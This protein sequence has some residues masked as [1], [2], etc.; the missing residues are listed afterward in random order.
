MRPS[1]LSQRVRDLRSSEIRDLLRL[2]EAPHVL[3]L[4]GGLPDPAGF[5]TAAL[6]RAAATVAGD[7][8]AL[9]YG[10]T[11]GLGEL[12]EHIAARAGE[13]LGRI[14]PVDE[15]VVTTGSQQ[16]L[17]LVARALCDPGDVVVVEDPGYLG[18]L[19][20]LRAAGVRV[21][22][23]PVDDDGLRVDSLDALLR[24]GLRPRLVYTV[25]TF[26]N[27]TG[28]TL[29]AERRAALAALAD[30]HGVVV[31]EDAPYEDLRFRGAS[32]PPVAAGTDRVVSLGSFSKTIAPGLRVGWARGPVD[33]VRALVTLK[34]ATDL[35]TS[36]LAQHLVLAL[37]RR[38]GWLDAHIA[39]SAAS[40]ARREAALAAAL[41]AAL[42]ERITVRRP[43]GGMFTWATLTGP[44]PDAPPPD[45]RALLVTAL[46]HDVAFVPGDAF[47]VDRPQPGAL[48]LSFA[49]VA[50]EQIDE[51]VAR[52]ARALVAHEA[53][54][55]VGSRPAAAVSGGGA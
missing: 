54:T 55:P 7:P 47:A 1:A 42:G 26:S 48:R 53:A 16:G 45:T 27:P 17:D 4:A 3:S 29:S 28:A 46:D 39:A 15:V 22:G 44:S 12:R 11:E 8:A 43:D 30:R 5:P 32:L 19:Q 21:V 13:R 38:P 51:A 9:Q 34:Q 20:A 40:Y 14:V 25:P 50:V 52:L 41:V 10:A 37:L 23:V 6:A 36:T 31:V 24:D 35:H 18:A 33:V 2:T 49:T